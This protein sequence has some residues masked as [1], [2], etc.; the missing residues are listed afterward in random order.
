MIEIDEPLALSNR[1]RRP[2]SGARSGT[3]TEQLTEGFGVDVADK[4]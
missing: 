3:R 2:S 1:R 4:A